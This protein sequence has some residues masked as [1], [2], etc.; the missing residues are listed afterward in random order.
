[1]TDDEFAREKGRLSSRS[2]RDRAALVR[3][4]FDQWRPLADV[5]VVVVELNVSCA[6]VY[7]WLARLR[8]EGPTGL[9][10]RPSRVNQPPAKTPSP[11][12]AEILLLRTKPLAGPARIGPWSV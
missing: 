3:R 9:V 6:A 12:E 4:V 10:D 7:K 2:C 11:L 1:M 8:A 5:D